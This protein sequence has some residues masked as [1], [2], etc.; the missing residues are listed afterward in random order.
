LFTK[1]LY[2]IGMPI[3]HRDRPKIRMWATQKKTR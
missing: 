3:V 2:G 1:F